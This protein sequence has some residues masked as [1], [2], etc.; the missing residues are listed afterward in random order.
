MTLL[1]NFIAKNLN[2][3]YNTNAFWKRTKGPD[4]LRVKKN[5]R[6]D[7][8]DRKF[9]IAS[10]NTRTMS[11][12]ALIDVYL[13]TTE[14]LKADI[15]GI[16]ETRRTNDL[17]AEW[18]NGDQVFLGKAFDNRSRKGGVG[19]I[20]RKNF[21]NLVKSCDFISPRVAVL[22]L[23]LEGHRTL[24]IIQVYAPATN[25][26]QDE[27]EADE[28]AEGFYHEVETALQISSTYTVV[29]GDFNAIVGRKAYENEKF[30]GNFGLGERNEK[31]SRLVSF[32]ASNKL[33]IMNTYFQKQG[34]RL[35]TWRSSDRRTLNQIDYVLTDTK[36]IFS[37]VSVIGEK[38]VNI[39]SDHRLL[40][41]SIAVK[42]DRENKILRRE[43]TPRM[44][45]NEATLSENLE[46][47]NF[48]VTAADIDEDYNEFVVKVKEVIDRSSEPVPPARIRRI[49]QGTKQLM[50][51]RA[52]RIA[53]GRTD[54]LEYK[55]LCKE[56]RKSLL[57][58]YEKYRIL[59]LRETAEKGKSL[60]KAERELQLKRKLPIALKD[61]NGKRVTD[62]LK[63]KE[64]CEK[65]YNSL[66]ASKV[67]I[68]EIKPHAEFEEILPVTVSE[69]EAAIRKLKPDKCPGKDKITAEHLKAGGRVLQKAIAERF[70]K[71]LQTATLPQAWSTSETVLLMKSGDTE[72]LGNYRPITLLS[73]IYKLF[74]RI[75]L[76]R[77][78]GNVEFSREQAGFRSGYSTLDHIHA[79]RQLLEKSKE[80]RVPVCLAFV[81][82]K[83]A[84]DSVETNAYLNALHEAGINPAYVDVVRSINKNCTTDIKMLSEVCRIN[85]SKGVRQGDT[86]SPKLF[87]ITLESL[88]RKIRFKGGVNIDG[89]RLTHLLFA[90]DC[91]LFASDPVDLQCNLQQ[92]ADDSKNVGLE[93]NLKKTKWMR[94]MQCAQGSITVNET[95]IEE[96][97]EYVYLGQQVQSN[98]VSSGEWTRRRQAA[99][100]AFNKNRT[101]LTDTKLPMEIRANLFNTT[102]LPAM[103]YASETWSTTKSEE[104]KLAVTQRAMERRMCGVS[105]KDK[106]SNKELRQR[107]GLRDVVD[108]IYLSK[109][110]WAGHIARLNDNRWTYRLTNWIPRDHRRPQG[111]PRN[112]WDGPMVKLFGQRWKQKACDRVFW[113]SVDLRLTATTSRM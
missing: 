87:A 35:W 90:D 64:I 97:T 12:D 83:K 40:R 54:G 77:I 27:E 14:K 37:D 94:N 59:R 112:R 76:Q 55:E 33:Y 16:C 6:A 20:V 24:K 44:K 110:R 69:V 13:E 103:L 104:K 31:G 70:T 91:V 51:V 85:I 28:E 81:D 84:F 88:F 41:S 49:Q 8:L 101:V 50:A 105:I 5:G 48:S 86:I 95:E 23:K 74:T 46:A 80:Y 98:N 11:S 113:R 32:A 111:R 4:G 17:V 3:K 65:F 71:Y 9:F 30:V 2:T 34:K 57:E 73:Q 75:L 58:D 92:L 109:R 96:V 78:F 67:R 38:V 60:K 93:I 45:V 19:F 102:V 29:Q 42:F 63:M 10:H 72:D 53:D 107:S 15:I 66:Y 82:Y 62:R 52:Q 22:L 36:R 21:V 106:I 79:V 100:I 61:E 108:G 25:S 99:W 39:G 47:M 43:K 56:I 1:Q 18:H 68:E 89:E 26:K 7:R